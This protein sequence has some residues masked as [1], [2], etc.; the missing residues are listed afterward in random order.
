MSAARIGLTGGIGSGKSTATAMFADLGVPTLDLDQ[1]GRQIT[2]PGSPCLNQLVD[3]FGAQILHSDGSLNRKALAQHCFA[4]ADETAK[5]NAIMHPR[6]QQAEAEWHA[7]QQAQYV[8]IEASVLL[9]SGGAQRMDAIIVVLAELAI[10]RA[11]VLH[12]GDRTAEEFETIVQRQCD[13]QLRRQH[14]DYII[15]NSGDRHALQRQVVQLHKQLNGRFT[16]A[17]ET[18]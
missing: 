6:I 17:S 3:T 11:R 14:A 8:I 9:E 7:A 16:S 10:R 2:P 18:R 1:L 15:D 13:D 4:N 12:R 5:L